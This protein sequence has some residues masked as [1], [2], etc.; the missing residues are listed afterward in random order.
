MKTGQMIIISSACGQS[1]AQWKTE[2]SSGFRS[3]SVLIVLKEN[4]AYNNFQ[5]YE[6]DKTPAQ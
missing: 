2:D 3:L 6:A 5:D 1:R 4:L